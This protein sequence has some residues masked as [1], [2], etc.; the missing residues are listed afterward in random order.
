MISGYMW[1]I[2]YTGPLDDVYSKAMDRWIWLI[3]V[4]NVRVNS[5]KLCN[6][7]SGVG[8]GMVVGIQMGVR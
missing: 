5:Q 6:N 1:L 8:S 2:D 7:R 4:V 3:I